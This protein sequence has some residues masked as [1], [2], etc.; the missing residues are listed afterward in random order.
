M[1]RATRLT[2]AAAVAAAALGAGATTASAAYAL[3]GGSYTGYGMADTEFTFAHAYQGNCVATFFRGNATG[4]SWTTFTPSFLDCTLFGFPATV[5]QSGSW[6]TEVLAGPTVGGRYYA[7]FIV[8]SSVTTTLSVP[9]AGC[10]VTISG[11]QSFVAPIQFRN[12]PGPI[13]LMDVD[14]SLIDYTASG[15][16]FSS[17]SDGRIRSA[18][19]LEVPWVTVSGP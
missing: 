13:A 7:D 8:P 10:T 19:S 9:I 11:P 4:A 15:C 16:P 17:G 18:A 3:S 2:T 1:G 14:V 5:T 12:S 6:T